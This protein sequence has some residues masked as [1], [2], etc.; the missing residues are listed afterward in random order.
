MKAPIFAYTKPL[1]VLF[2]ASTALLT[3]PATQAGFK[4]F[5]DGTTL[6]LK[7]TVDDGA[8]TLDNNGAGDAFRATDGF[9]TSTFV[10]ATHL[11]V[12]LLGGTSNALNF[13]LDNAHTGN[14]MLNLGD[15]VRATSFIGTGNSIGGNLLVTGGTDA[16]TLELA[17]NANLGV[18]RSMTINLGTGIDSVDEDNNDIS[19]G[20][21]WTFTGVNFFENGGVMSVGGNVVV[22][23][24]GETEDTLFDDDN[25]MAIT[26]DF[27]YTGGDGRD[28]VTMNGVGGGTTVG[29]SAVV[30][31]GDNTTGG[32]QFI[33]FNLPGSSVAGSMTVTST[34][35]TTLDSY[36]EHPMGKIGGNVSIDLGGG[37]NNATIVANHGGSTLSYTGGGGVDTV[38][39]GPTTASHDATLSL[40]DGDNVL[41]LIASVSGD[42]TVNA[43]TGV[44]LVDITSPFTIGGAFTA[45]LGT[46]IDTLGFVNFGLDQV[47]FVSQTNNGALLSV[48]TGGLILTIEQH[49]SGNN[50]GIERLA[51]E[52]CIYRISK[53][54]DFESGTI[55]DILGGCILFENGFE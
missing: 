13:D 40:G 27:T 30:N 44:D 25:T 47:V 42:L 50:Y 48:F 51:A 11:V 3:A 52:G 49:F 18:A 38:T 37:V 20:T 45:N 53:D 29:G 39:F 12:N 36:S 28:E 15:G 9:G 24:S 2:L 8:I 16:Q 7:Q 35:V 33:F 1:F 43:G 26:G 23:S 10:A 5:F 41:S 34:A 17:V 54:S 21:D 31:V 6:T 46:G 4:G 22:D 19:V 14:V 55:Q 32:V